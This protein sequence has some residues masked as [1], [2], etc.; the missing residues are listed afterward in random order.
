M[1][2]LLMAGSGD[3]WEGRR[4]TE[5]EWSRF[6]EHTQK[7]VAEP[8]KERDSVDASKLIAFAAL[9]LP[10]FAKTA[11]AGGAAE[12]RQFAYIGR[13]IEVRLRNN[14]IQ[15][16]YEFD[17]KYSPIPIS[18]IRDLAWDLDINLKGGENYRM[19]WALKDVDL[20]ET[21]ARG[22]AINQ[23]LP[24]DPAIAD[25]LKGLASGGMVPAN[26]S[27]KASVFIVH[28]RE[29]GIKNEVA[30]WISQIGMNEVV[31]HEQPNQGR[32]IISKFSDMAAIV[33]YAIVIVTPDDIGGLA[34]AQLAPRARQNVIFE[35]GFFI[36]A[37]GPTRVAVLLS[38]ER[39][40][41]PSDYDGVVYTAYDR[42]GAWKL[43][44][45]REFRELGLPFDPMRA[46]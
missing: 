40:E 6:L 24:V 41:R 15:F 33:D 13:I 5:I 18:K 29:D 31:L 35:F 17:D 26:K 9:F 19:H 11:D 20:I 38:D 27:T 30:R 34:E 4:V 43:A 1:Y 46:F 36:G 7:G 39:I 23:S 44:L 32:T 37:L 8:F 14:E 22:G 45:A 12:E 28:G 21:L 3:Y 42:A 10:E 16:K 2:N 25:E